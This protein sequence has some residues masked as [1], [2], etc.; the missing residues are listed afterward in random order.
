MPIAAMLTCL[1][2]LIFRLI[3]TLWDVAPR[4][5]PVPA[6]D[7]FHPELSMLRKELA[8]LQKIVAAQELSIRAATSAETQATT[9][10]G[11]AAD[12]ARFRDA[13]AA[14]S[15]PSAN[16]A[17]GEAA[18]S[19]NDMRTP[20]QDL[21]PRPVG[22]VGPAPGTTYILGRKTGRETKRVANSKAGA[23]QSGTGG[24]D[25]VKHTTPAEEE[26]TVAA[27]VEPKHEATRLPQGATGRV[28]GRERMREANKK[29]GS[30]RGGKGGEE[31]RL[32]SKA[33]SMLRR[34]WVC[35]RG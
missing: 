12:A 9:A 5:A 13:M 26:D 28:K 4:P 32:G 27:A 25:G 14:T 34:K 33:V 2:V 23:G 16:A 10:D 35:G 30:A 15:Q 11:T 17:W 29:A 31:A 22:G 20:Q 18:S 21:D 3:S 24:K 19:L 8:S 7:Q 1:L 6:T